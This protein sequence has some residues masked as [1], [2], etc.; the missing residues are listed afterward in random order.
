DSLLIILTQSVR[1]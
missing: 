1:R